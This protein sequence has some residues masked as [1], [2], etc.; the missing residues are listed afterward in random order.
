MKN[1]E[2]TDFFFY[3]VGLK[4]RSFRDN[5]SLSS[6]SI[7]IY[8]SDGM[9]SAKEFW[10]P[11]WKFEFFSAD[12]LFED[13]LLPLNSLL[14]WTLALDARLELAFDGPLDVFRPLIEAVWI[15]YEISNEV[16][17]IFHRIDESAS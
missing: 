5:A 10:S 6:S 8:S 1:V 15:S 4:S 3:F 17:N 9:L 12:P 13:L 11:I 7:G 2:W 16:E 14:F